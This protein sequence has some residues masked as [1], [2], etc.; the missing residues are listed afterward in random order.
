MNK[1]ECL[2]NIEL[3]AHALLT[4]GA[5]CELC[6]H[7]IDHTLRV[8]RN[9][10]FIGNLEKLDED[11][12]FV[13]KAIAWFHDLG[14]TKCYAGHEDAS[15]SIASEFLQSQGLEKSTID[16]VVNGIDA[17]RVP[18]KP[19][20]KIERIIADADLFD[21]GTDEYFEL[22][23][24][25]FN[26]WDDCI[27]PSAREDHWNFSLAFLKGHKYFTEYGKEVL[28]LKKLNNIS[29]LERKLNV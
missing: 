2:K 18:Q 16:A 15:M 20:D 12:M 26:E 29:I 22:S 3:F 25:L 10:E 7:N 1:K 14:Y 23:E 4:E 9:A 27:K 24:R 11:Q 6:Y 28:E 19:K 17:T 21:L 13:I 5:V 8:V